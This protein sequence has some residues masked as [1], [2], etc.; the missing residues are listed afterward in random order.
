MLANTLGEVTQKGA[1]HKR[2]SEIDL[3][4]Y[5]EAAIQFTT[6]LDLKVD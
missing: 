3:A 6:S 5:N 1:E 2:D 4:W